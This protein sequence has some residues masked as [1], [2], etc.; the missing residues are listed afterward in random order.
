MLIEAGSLGLFVLSALALNLT[1][2]PDMLFT[3]A[4][5]LKQGPRA[6]IVAAVFRSGRAISAARM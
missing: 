1:P 3:T 6:G 2:G 4:S 5:G